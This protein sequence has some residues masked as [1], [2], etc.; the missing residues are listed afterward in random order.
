LAFLSWAALITASSSTV[1]LSRDFFAWLSTHV[2]ADDSSTRAF[3]GFWA[4]A[5]FP[6]VKGWH[7]TEF[8]ILVLFTHALL[9]RLYPSA[10]RRNLALSAMFGALFALSD[11]YHQTFVPGR[12]GTWRDVA[13]DLI[14]V[15]L[16]CALVWRRS[17]LRERALGSSGK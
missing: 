8:A 7:V 6:I 1:I 17:G 5:W 4:I 10:R 16:A 3:A 2:F 14:G 13:I 15:A 11:E 12:G 9:E